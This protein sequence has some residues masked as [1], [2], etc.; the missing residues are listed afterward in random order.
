MDNL[1][2]LYIG[3]RETEGEEGTEKNAEQIR[4]L[5]TWGPYKAF[6]SIFFF[7]GVKEGAKRPREENRD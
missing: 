6:S 7:F 4:T 2:R 3:K 1:T 5:T